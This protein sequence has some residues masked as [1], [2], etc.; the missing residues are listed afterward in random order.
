MRS[1][2]LAAVVAA[3]LAGCQQRS[4]PSAAP[5][6]HLRISELLNQS[7][8]FGPIDADWIRSEP[9]RSP[10]GRE[11]DRVHGGIQ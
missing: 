6:A 11:P 7:E 4:R 2:L 5:D 10:T 3:S 1:F 8:S 9:V